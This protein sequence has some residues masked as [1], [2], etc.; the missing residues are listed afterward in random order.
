MGRF[1]SF[2]VQYDAQFLTGARYLETSVVGSARA[3]LIEVG[4][5]FELQYASSGFSYSRQVRV[6]GK[7]PGLASESITFRQALRNLVSIKV[8]IYLYIFLCCQMLILT[9]CH[10]N[11]PRLSEVFVGGVYIY[12]SYPNGLSDNNLST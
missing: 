2:P 12:E 1:K 5:L 3:T 4:A 7:C 8:L 9:P 6:P 10:L 11:P